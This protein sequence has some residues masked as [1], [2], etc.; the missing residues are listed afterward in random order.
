[1][2]LFL[3]LSLALLS[4]R[5]ETLDAVLARMDQAAPQFKSY[6]ATMKRQEYTAVLNETTVSKGSMR[7][8][9]AKTGMTGVIDFTEPDPMTVYLNG[10]TVQRFFPKAHTVEIYDVGKYAHS[11]DEVI[12]VGFGTSGADLKKQ[13]DIKLG[14]S[15]TV[16]GVT[17]SRLEL[18]PKDSETRKLVSKIEMWIPEGQAN[19]IQEK[20]S[21]PSKDYSIIN[22][23]D[24]KI[25]PTL[26]DSD[27]T[28]TLPAGVKKIYPQK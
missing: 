26:P 19:P 11:I 13:Y 21:P 3:G 20:L 7:L 22:F 14:G 12:L 8:K 24:V 28:L 4:A 10:K 18:V 17:T 6:S 2:R 27:Y 15:E 5:A 25:N 16:A 9:R 1:M 23:S